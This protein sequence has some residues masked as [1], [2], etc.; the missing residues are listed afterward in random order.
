MQYPPLSSVTL[1]L[2]LRVHAV[3]SRHMRASPSTQGHGMTVERWEGQQW[4]TGHSTLFAGV[5]SRAK[6][7]IFSTVVLAMAVSAS[8][9]KKP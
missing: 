3:S 6:L 9:V 4:V 8:R 7:V 2:D 5:P 1:G